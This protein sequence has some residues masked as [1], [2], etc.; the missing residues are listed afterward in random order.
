[1]VPLELR[2]RSAWDPA[3]EYWAEADQPIE[4]WAKPIIAR[5]RRPQ[6]EMEQV[7]LPGPLAWQVHRV[8]EEA[9]N[10]SDCSDAV[11]EQVPRFST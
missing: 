1:M 2:A 11:E 5:G 10:F 4:E 3:A 8:V 6:F 9:G 7:P